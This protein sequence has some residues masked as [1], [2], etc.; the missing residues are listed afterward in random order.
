MKLLMKIVK[1]SLNEI[2]VLGTRQETRAIVGAATAE[3][4]AENIG[5]IEALRITESALAAETAKATESAR[6]CALFKRGM[7]VLVVHGTFFLV[8]QGV[9]SF[10]DFFKFF[11]RF[12][13]VRIA[14]GMVFH[15]QLAVGFFDFIVASAAG[16]TKG[17]VIILGTH[18]FDSVLNK[19]E[20]GRICGRKVKNS[21]RYF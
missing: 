10:L 12:F 21:S 9:V 6:T 14:V 13:V 8:R 4:L 5:K 15:C 17:F 1:S 7:A 11:F 20:L 3:H 18:N 16:N 2:D 19:F